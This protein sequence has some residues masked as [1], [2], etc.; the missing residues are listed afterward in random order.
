MNTRL[1][2]DKAGAYSNSIAIS[3]HASLKHIPD[4]E[5]PRDQ[6]RVIRRPVASMTIRSVA[7]RLNSGRNTS[8][9]TTARSRQRLKPIRRIA[10]TRLVR[11]HQ[12]A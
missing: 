3:A 12:R 6:H 9:S 5:F 7:R 11:H 1:C 8:K 10:E 2:F 4:A